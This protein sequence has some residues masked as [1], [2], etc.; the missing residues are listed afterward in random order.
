MN[1]S[2]P[3]DQVADDSHT[4]PEIALIYADIRSILGNPVVNL[5]FRRLAALGV[6]VLSMVWQGIRPA[7][8]DG[9][10]N[11]LADALAPPLPGP[12]AAGGWAARADAAVMRRIVL[13]YDR[14]N[15]CNLIALTALFA[16]P[17]DQAPGLKLRQGQSF[18]ALHPDPWSV[19]MQAAPLAGKVPPLPDP[20]TLAAPTRA[21]L[22]RLDAFGDPGDGPPEASLYRHLAH[23]PD[24][25]LDA[26][27]ALA[28]LHRQGVLLQATATVQ[29]QARCA[30]CLLPDLAMEPAFQ[31]RI[32]PAVGA[33]VRRIIPKMIPI[34]RALGT[35][36]LPSDGDA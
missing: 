2:D 21:C 14:N 5:V 11:A 9:R 6:P 27:A 23:W 32:D 25:L 10:L 13:D 28:P 19:A 26:E 16:A 31:A 17:Q 1:G 34:G 20:V 35:L 15:Q 18:R 4:P 29:A 3:A 30:A 24:F 36:V 12:L 8:A 22:A 7:Y 33:L